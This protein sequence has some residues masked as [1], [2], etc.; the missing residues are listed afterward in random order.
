MT[1]VKSVILVAAIFVLVA[2][3]IFLAAFLQYLSVQLALLLLIALLGLYLGF[4]VLI[5]V[6]RFTSKLK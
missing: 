1:M 2:L 3:G 6:Y 4:G 5:A